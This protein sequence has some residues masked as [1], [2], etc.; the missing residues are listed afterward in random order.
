MIALVTL[1]LAY[2]ML[3]R[4]LGWLAL[5]ARS[6]AAKDVESLTLRHEVAVLRRTNPHPKMS[7]LDRAVLSALSRLLPATLRRMRLASPRTLLLPGR[8]EDFL[9]GAFEQSVVDGDGE[10]GA[11]REESGDD[12][13]GQCQSE[14]VTRPAGVGEQSMRAAVMPHLIQPGAGQHSTHRSA[15]GLSDQADNQP[16]EGLECRGGKARPEHGQEPGRR[17]RCGGPGRHRRI[18]LTRTV[19]ER[20]MLSPSRF[21]IQNRSSPACPRGVRTSAAPGNCE[22]RATL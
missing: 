9:P 7:W 13:I 8:S 15:A 11:R 19:N 10:R 16:D 17:A 5:L 22:T 6:D 2:L 4:V 3:V 12:Q 18:T 14:R 20:S 1:R 21:K